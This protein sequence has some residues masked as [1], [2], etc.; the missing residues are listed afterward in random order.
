VIFVS[1]PNAL[2]KQPQYVRTPALIDQVI[3][4]SLNLPFPRRS[5]FFVGEEAMNR[6]RFSK[7]AIAITTS[8]AALLSFVWPGAIGTA[9][10]ADTSAWGYYRSGYGAWGWDS[11]GWGWDSGPYAG[12]VGTDWGY[13]GGA[14]PYSDP[15]AGYRHTLGTVATVGTAFDARL[16]TT[17]DA[18]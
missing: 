13:R 10:A 5:L 12:Y 17:P 18:L 9:A 4:D 16:L 7:V 15:N 8:A 11:R 14:Y 6:T 1:G 2:R 3:L